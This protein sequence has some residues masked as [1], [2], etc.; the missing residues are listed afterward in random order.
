MSIT[1]PQ[2]PQ[3]FSMYEEFAEAF[4]SE[5]V[6]HSVVTDHELPEGAGTVAVVRLDNGEAKR[7]TTLGARSLLEFGRVVA[8]QRQRAQSGEISALAVT[9]TPGYL[10]AGADLSSV[11]TLDNAD[12]ARLMATL[13][14]QTYQ[15]LED[16]PV[17]TFAFI[18]G[19]AIGGGLEIALAAHY[20]TVSR[21]AR[22]ISLPEIYLG[23]IPGWGGIYRLPRLIGPEAAAQ[24]IFANALANNRQLSGEDAYELGIADEIHS[25]ASFEEDSLT[26][27]SRVLRED[28]QT[29]ESLRSRREVGDS[30]EDWEKAVQTARRTVTA[31]VGAATPAPLRALEVF[32]AGASR[33]R[34]EDREAE[35]DA[36]TDLMMTDE[37][38]NTVYAF[39]ELTQKR[40]RRP[41]GVPEVEPR[42]IGSVGVVGAG[43]MASQLALLFARRLR[44]PVMMT[45]IDQERVDRG[46]GWV[47]AQVEKLVSR[48]R[49]SPEDGQELAG[50]VTGSSSYDAYADVDF[51]I[52]AV[53][54]ELSVKQQVFGA[55]EEVISPETIVATN[56][57]SLSVRGMSASMRHP[58]RVVGFH[59]FNPVAAM[60]LIEIARTPDTDDTTVASAFALAAGLGKTP[61]LTTDSPA[62]VVNRVLL[63]LMTEVQ[64]AFDEGTD[65]ET[66]DTALAPM[67]LPMSPFTLL[68]MVGLPVAQHVAESLHQAHGERFHVSENLQRLIDEGVTE[69]WSQDE[70]GQQYVKDS[71]SSILQHGS[72][73]RSGEQILQIVQDALAEEIGLMLTEGVVSSPRDIDL[74]MILGAGWPLHLGGITPYLDQVGASERVNGK[75]FSA[76]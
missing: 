31:R 4:T 51:V 3:D 74:C 8:H 35:V 39:L 44:V 25:E 71:T 49:L 37:F 68:A 23:L 69:I 27:V 10:A 21:A 47:R 57:S 64:R 54:E 1:F 30:A 33:T 22:G 70:S 50:L 2:D 14:H 52:E 28:G 34:A 18:N 32:A 56:T 20:R 12:S 67:G 58:E 48:G 16:F 40:A 7:P 46:V 62:F 63:R 17:P 72:Q 29:V 9:G 5:V 36:L 19:A 26:F 76:R 43:L 38:A 42:Q 61:V 73:P 24:V 55:L 53:F 41:A 75:P 11:S 65:A 59:F 45:D 66:A 15:V 60:P 6:T 13:G